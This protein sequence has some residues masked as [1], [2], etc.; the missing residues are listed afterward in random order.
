MKK[1]LESV[2]QERDKTLDE[3]EAKLRMVN[4]YSGVEA[5]KKVN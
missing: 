2:K 3:V 4:E 1:E 5:E